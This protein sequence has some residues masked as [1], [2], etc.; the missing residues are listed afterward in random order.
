[1]VPG[2]TPIAT[3]ARLAALALSLLAAVSLVAQ[4]TLT[5][6]TPAGGTVAATL[7]SMGGYFTILTNA[8]V[9]V[10]FGLAA[11]R[12]TVAPQ[13]V[14]GVTLA[15]VLVALVYHPFLAGLR[16]LQGLALWVDHGLH[17]AVP[18]L[19]LVWWI[20]FAPKS[21][22]FRDLPFWLIW[23]SAYAIYAL[24]RGALTGFWAYPFLDADKLGWVMV[25]RNVATLIAA[26]VVLGLALI[27]VARGL[28]RRSV[29]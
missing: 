20:V 10:T 27:A 7:W 1:M 16:V 19:A 14:A 29:R 25:A 21:V 15:I 5:H 2:S 9:A 24:S 12:G 6:A 18:A 11:L 26:F 4:F 13:R 3:P 17:S 8:L 28:D 23:P 22:T